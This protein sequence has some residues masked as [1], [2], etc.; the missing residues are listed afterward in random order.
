MLRESVSRGLSD[1]LTG[2]GDVLASSATG[3]GFSNES[4]FGR[5][6]PNRT[7]R[8]GQLAP[9]AGVAAAVALSSEGIAPAHDGAFGVDLELPNPGVVLG[10]GQ[11]QEAL[12]NFAFVLRFRPH[13]RARDAA[14][15]M[16]EILG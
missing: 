13:V 6:M 3:P 7:F 1:S 12:L 2:N 4:R 9:A 5:E 11:L 14:N 15:P 10:V 8:R 16:S